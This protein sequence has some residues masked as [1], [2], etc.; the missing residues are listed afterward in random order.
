MLTITNH[1]SKAAMRYTSH[2]LEWISSKTQEI[3]SVGEDLKKK[4]PWC[5]VSENANWQ[6]HYEKHY[7]SF[8]KN[9]KNRTTICSSN[10]IPGYLSKENKNT[11]SKRY[12]HY[13][14][15]SSIIYSCQDMKTT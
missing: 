11:I 6:N 2:P 12:M 14:V 1:Q 7:G 3:R 13:N 9:L 15:H 10:S 8:S 4:E 5:T